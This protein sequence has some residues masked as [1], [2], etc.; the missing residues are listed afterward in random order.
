MRRKLYYVA[1]PTYVGLGNDFW[2]CTNCNTHNQSGEK[3]CW[4]CKCTRQGVKPKEKHNDD[5]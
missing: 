5:M 1:E 4:I 2:R 3:A